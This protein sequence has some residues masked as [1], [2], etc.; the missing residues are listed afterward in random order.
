MYSVHA[1]HCYRDIGLRV[2]WYDE[3]IDAVLEG[4]ILGN[5]SYA[6]AVGQLAARSNDGYGIVSCNSCGNP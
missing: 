2:L 1:M 3:R 5:D 6:D 4:H